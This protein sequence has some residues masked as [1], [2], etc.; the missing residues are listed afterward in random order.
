[1]DSLAFQIQA[2]G[3][4]LMITDLEYLLVTC[5]SKSDVDPLTRSLCVINFK[6]LK[7]FDEG[8][9]TSSETLF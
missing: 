4:Y 2:A 6:T 1:M 5:H 9:C 3:H 7:V 8:A